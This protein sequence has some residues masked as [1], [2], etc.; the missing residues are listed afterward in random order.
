M[1]YSNAAVMS[2]EDE[3]AETVTSAW[4]SSACVGVTEVRN[5]LFVV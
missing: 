3:E 2:T 5:I 4:N 1:V